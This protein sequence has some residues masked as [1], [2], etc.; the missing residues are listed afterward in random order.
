MSRI[1]P[2]LLRQQQHGAD[3]AGGEALDA[4]GEFVVDVGGGHHGLFAFGSGPI[5]RCGR[6]FS[7]CGRWKILRLR[8]R[9]SCG[10]VFGSPRG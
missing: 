4:I 10:C 8:S 1:K 9:A 6:G 2:I 3:A 7:A 5:A